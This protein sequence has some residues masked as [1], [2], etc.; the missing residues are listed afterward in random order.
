[1]AARYAAT[2]EAAGAA[3]DE[4][5]GQVV[6]KGIA[7]GVLHK[8]DAGAVVVGLE[9]RAAVE[10]AARDMAARLASQG[11]PIERF[12]LQPQIS[13]AVEMLVGVTHDSTFGPVVACGAGGTLVELVKDVVVRLAP[14]TEREADEMLAS[15]RTYPLLTGYRGSPPADVT[16]L[17]T[18]LLRVGRM[19]DY[20]H[21]IVEMD[22]NPVMV[23]PDGKGVAVVDARVRVAETPPDIPL[24]AKKR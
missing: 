17:R 15:L 19:A 4:L 14:L 13:E 20:L 22:L 1:V 6:L 11:H 10:S 23:L 21:G 8:R 9:G 12:L 16:A 3:A 2:P 18:L 7:P 5:G 24:G